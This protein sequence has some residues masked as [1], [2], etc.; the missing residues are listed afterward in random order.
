MQKSKLE[1]LSSNLSEEE[2]KDLLEKI[3]KS[4]EES[5][6]EY[7]V[8]VELAENDRKELI[9]KE[10]AKL[11]LW[12]RFL[13]WIRR[14]LSGR[15]RDQIF[16]SMKIADIKRSIQRT[17]PGL[18]GF[19]TRELSVK[20]IKYVFDLY[21]ETFP[22]RD[23]YQYYITESLFREQLAYSL[24]ADRYEKAKN[25]LADFIDVV[26]LET[27]FAETNSQASIQNILGKRFEEYIKALP[28]DLFQK[29]ERELAPLLS[30]KNVAL[31]NFKELFQNFDYY[32][33]PTLDKKYPVFRSCPALIVI[34]HLERLYYS[35]YCALK[36]A[37]S[38]T[39]ISNEALSVYVLQKLGL[40]AFKHRREI[41]KR[42]AE[43]QGEIAILKGRFETLGAEILR[44][45]QSVPLLELIRYFR[46]DPFYR[47][48]FYIPPLP[49]KQIYSQFLRKN[50]SKELDAKINEIKDRVI[51]RKIR[52]LFQ[53]FTMT[54]FQYYT[55]NAADYFLRIG[56]PCF[57]RVKS[58][59][60][61][62][63]Y[64]R[65]IYRQFIQ[66]VVQLVGAFFFTNNKRNQNRLL[67]FASSIEELEDKITWFDRALSPDEDD[68]K[69]ILRLKY[70]IAT[71]LTHQ[72]LYKTFLLEKDRDAQNLLEKGIEFFSGFKGI[73]DEISGAPTENLQSVMKTLVSY[74]NRQYTMRQVIDLLST[75]VGDFIR[76][77]SQ[78][79]EMEKGR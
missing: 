17:T 31:F 22:V 26:E 52:E 34:D 78:V 46:R 76:L 44:F 10:I 59:S 15:D 49:L 65:K 64:I 9:N 33:P 38:A 42:K 36:S 50:L 2:R 40:D 41:E 73:F 11:T 68:G 45:S 60:L 14:L 47:F 39:A 13:L 23:F 18:S 55:D 51:D 28:G 71:D 67:Q 6:G 5:D 30:M 54:P 19:E 56:L 16:L 57:S 69:T 35:L 66:E 29:I 25:G 32:L 53:D 75:S 58:L 8:H 79:M 61:L 7:Y 21:S 77:L 4:M 48:K 3:N 62:Y 74:K 20:F 72:K 43:I 27:V 37:E 12:K 24:V 1:E 70:N 63:N